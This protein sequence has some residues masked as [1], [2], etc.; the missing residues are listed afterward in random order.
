[1]ISTILNILFGESKNNSSNKVKV[2]KVT[3]SDIGVSLTIVGHEMQSNDQTILRLKRE[4]AALLRH[5]SDLN[6]RIDNLDNRQLVLTA[7]SRKVRNIEPDF[8]KCY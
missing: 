7:F 1:M 5:L 8:Y 4:R 6:N 2:E 3:L